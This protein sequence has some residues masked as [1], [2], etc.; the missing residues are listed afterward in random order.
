MPIIIPVTRARRRPVSFPNGS[1]R[2]GPLACRAARP[3]AGDHRLGGVIYVHV[4]K[5]GLASPAA[6]SRGL[7]AANRACTA[8]VD[9]L[10]RTAGLAA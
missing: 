5:A 1:A 6:G 9:D 8:A 2:M 3:K 10:A 4:R 7:A